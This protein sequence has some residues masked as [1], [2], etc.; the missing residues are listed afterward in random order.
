MY[1][2]GSDSIATF[3]KASD[4]KLNT[5]VSNVLFIDGHVDERK[6]YDT[7]DLQNRSSSKSYN[8]ALGK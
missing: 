4:A 3:H 8:L 6:A 2:A 5:G 1:G 7:Q